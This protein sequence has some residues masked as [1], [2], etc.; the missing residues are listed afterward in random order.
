MTQR[1]SIES[2][3]DTV[4]LQWSL[5]PLV[6]GQTDAVFL[7]LYTAPYPG[8]VDSMTARL[9]DDVQDGALS[10]DVEVGATQQEINL[11]VATDAFVAYTGR[12]KIGKYAFNAGDTIALTYTSGT[13]TVNPRAD[14]LVLLTFNKG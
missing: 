12:L 5:D 7:G 8:W 10:F 9:D 6:D 13:L 14:V 1:E 2:Q 11:A 3:F 4:A